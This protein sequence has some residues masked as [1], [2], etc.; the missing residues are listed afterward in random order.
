[1]GKRLTKEEFISRA[2]VV[3]GDRY[4]YSLV[5]YKNSRTRVKIICPEHGIF[6]QS[7][8][9]HFNGS[10]C[11]SCANNIKYSTQ[12]FVKKAKQVNGNRY[13]YSLVEYKNNK[14]K[15][16]IICPEHGIF[17]QI[18]M[19]HLKEIGCFK[20]S[21]N[22]NTADDFIKKAKDVHGDKYDYSLVDYKNNYTKVKIICLE[23]G[24][25]EQIPKNH[26]NHERGCPVCNESRGE[27]EIALLLDENNISHLRQYKFEECKNVNHLPFDFYLPEY[28]LCIEYDG[29]Q[30]YEAVEFF[31]GERGLRYIQ[32]NDEI[33]NKYC[34]DNN[35]KLLRIK[36]ND[37]I[38]EKLI[39]LRG[40]TQP[41]V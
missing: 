20:C 23:H 31:G 33:K 1:M 27:K 25:F 14:T 7:P 8:E 2:I 10:G 30:H 9:F 41:G 11:P 6:E 13:D 40:L 3:H 29:R 5:D 16:K 34:N 28:N 39:F 35:I 38:S 24:M 36:Y 17:E 15:I 26:T 32:K 37:N 12:E 22:F 19:H 18:P 4:D 21:H